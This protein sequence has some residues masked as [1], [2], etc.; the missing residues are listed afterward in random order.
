VPLHGTT[1]LAVGSI[2]VGCVVLGL[3]FL[4]YAMTGSVALFSDAL[5]SIINVAAAGA[6]VVALSVGNLPADAN[7]PYGHHKAE[8]FSSVLE[9]ALIVVA[10]FAILREAYFGLIHPKP[11]DVPA[12]GLAVNGAATALNGVWSWVL[13]RKGRLWRSP[14]LVADGKHLY[15]DVVTSIGVLGGVALAGVTGWQ[16]L[17]PLLAAAVAV[18]IVWSGWGLVRESVGGLMD[19]APAPEEL[20]RI[21]RIIADHAKGAIE[22]HDLRARNASRRTFIEFH[23]IVPGEMSVHEAH[24]IC[25]RLEE[26][27]RR[28]VDESTITIHVEPEYKAKRSGVVDVSRR[29]V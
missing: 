14:A 8:Y 17:D 15:T 24:E 28:E 5:E 16:P 6:A 3:K 25:D 18:N 27:L 11:L 20:D 7:H 4:A 26:A 19:E 2:A 12:L 9:G 1:K 23:L 29:A 10:A 21:R 13:I 22:A